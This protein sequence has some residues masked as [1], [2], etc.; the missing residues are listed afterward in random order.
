MSSSFASQRAMKQ[1]DSAGV[2]SVVMGRSKRAKVAVAGLAPIARAVVDQFAEGVVIFNAQGDLVYASQAAK[3]VALGVLR[4]PDD[5]EA[6]DLVPQLVELGGRVRHI[7]VGSSTVGQAV[8]LPASDRKRTLAE[9]ERETI[10]TALEVN[11]WRLAD[12]A[13]QL[14]ISRTTLWRRLK[15]YGLRGNREARRAGLA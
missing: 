3:E 6:T 14:G 1:W 11:G 7:R 8:Y 10:L 4:Q 9:T 15:A 13:E 2:S 12:T 5:A